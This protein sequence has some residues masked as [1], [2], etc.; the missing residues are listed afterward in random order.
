MDQIAMCELMCGI[1]TNDRL[2]S[3]L[4]ATF[5]LN[6]ELKHYIALQFKMH[7]HCVQVIKKLSKFYSA[8]WF[9]RDATRISFAS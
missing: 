3:G 7:S 2:P 8:Q 5:E 4:K 6:D 9:A 1:V